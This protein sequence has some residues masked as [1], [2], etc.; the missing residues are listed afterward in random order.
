[1]N[2]LVLS[3]S[4]LTMLA[5]TQLT[6]VGAHRWQMPSHVP[7]PRIHPEGLTR[8]VNRIADSKYGLIYPLP[9]DPRASQP[10]T[11]QQASPLAISL[12]DLM[13]EIDAVEQVEA[14]PTD[15]PQWLWPIIQQEA[16]LRGLDPVLLESLIRQESGFQS[17]A[18]SP[19]GAQGLTQL[20]PE[21][22]QLVGVKDVFDARQNVAGGAEYLS[23]QLHDFGGDLTLA[24]AAYNA[25]PGAVRRWGGVPPYAETINYVN[26]I[27][28]DYRSKGNTRQEGGAAPEAE[29]ESAGNDSAGNSGPQPL[30]ATLLIPN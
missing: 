19:L 5:C 3:R 10:P 6:L 24:L 21:T 20:M 29:I 30:P 7:P 9:G 11:L 13:D 16:Q 26:A 18:V 27:L 28:D 25:G 15:A 2:R 1:M 23:W 8:L 14:V 4:L 12:A 17:E 22:A